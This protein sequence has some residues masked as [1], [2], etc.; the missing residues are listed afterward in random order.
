[1]EM[2]RVFWDEAVALDPSSE[3]R[4][5]RRMPLCRPGELTSVWKAQGLLQVREDALVIPLLFSSF[6]DFWLPFLGGQGP[7]GAYVASLSESRRLELEERVRRR[8]NPD[9][10][11]APIALKARAWAVA[12]IVPER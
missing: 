9:G 5:E 7:A 11:D 8:L 3:Q 10:V 4:D 2:L 6:S 12:G 1:M